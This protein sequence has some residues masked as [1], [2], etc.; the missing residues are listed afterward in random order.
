[1]I[2]NSDV[3]ADVGVPDGDILLACI[4]R[5]DGEVKCKG[6]VRSKSEERRHALPDRW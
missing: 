2:T 1:M 3:Q 5:I 6:A 4:G